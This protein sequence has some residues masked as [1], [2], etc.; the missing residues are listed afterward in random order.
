MRFDQAAV[1]HVGTPSPGFTKWTSS[2]RMTKRICFHGISSLSTERNAG[3]RSSEFEGLGNQWSLEIYPGGR[4]DSAAGMSS[5]HLWNKSNKAIE[6]DFGVSIIDGNG[7]QVAISH[8]ATPYYF[9]PGNG[10]GYKDF[11]SVQR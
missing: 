4:G 9:D 11:L 8:S 6:V 3:V 10:N 2:E 5:L 1:L 7:N